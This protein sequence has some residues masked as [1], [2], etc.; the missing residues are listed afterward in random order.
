V[1]FRG[2]RNE[3]S[4]ILEVA[5]KLAEIKNCSIKEVGN[6]TSKNAEFIFGV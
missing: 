3:P 4:Y 5:K 2:K 1:P 6:I